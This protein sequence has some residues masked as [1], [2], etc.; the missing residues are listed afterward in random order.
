MLRA[1][2]L[3]IACGGMAACVVAPILHFFGRIEVK[4]YQDVFLAGSVIWFVFATWWG[5]RRKDPAAS[6]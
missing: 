4:T 3:I 5:T 6:S 1:L 2:L